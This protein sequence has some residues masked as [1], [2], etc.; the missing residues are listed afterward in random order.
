MSL[1]KIFEKV[2]PVL[3]LFA[4]LA[5]FA[6]VAWSVQSVQN[7]YQHGAERA[8]T[9]DADH[10]DAETWTIQRLEDG[11]YEAKRQ[12][13]E[14]HDAEE[15]VFGISP[16]GWIAIFTVVLAIATIGLIL[17]THSLGERAD[18]GLRQLERA[19]VFFGIRI[20]KGELHFDPA[21]IPADHLAAIFY[22][23]N[24]GKTPGFIKEF[25]V[26]SLPVIPITGN[27]TYPTSDRYRRVFFSDQPV[28][29]D[30]DQKLARAALDTKEDTL[31]YGYIKYTDIF[32]RT[33]T[34][35][36]CIIL[37]AEAL[38]ETP[39]LIYS[40]LHGPPAWNEWD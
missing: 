36:F 13:A 21:S 39:P 31:F 35:R 24:L 1:S 27:P 15:E 28:A 40:D 4:I 12:T 11:S 2:A 30:G 14:A 6:L 3:A 32:R 26:R 16:E 37:R 9:P 38:R 23:Q 34:S 33:H 10:P 25:Y 20:N 8:H 19:Y 22:A 29:R 17:A 7:A 5:A 18:R